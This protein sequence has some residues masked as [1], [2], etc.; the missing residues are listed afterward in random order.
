MRSI[1]V[2]LEL[3]VRLVEGEAV[4]ELLIMFKLLFEDRPVHRRT[5]LY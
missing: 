5:P 4:A 2:P 3:T 1:V